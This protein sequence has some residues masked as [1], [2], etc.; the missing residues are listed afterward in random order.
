MKKKSK[1]FDY[2]I[3][4]TLDNAKKRINLLEKLDKKSVLDEYNEWLNDGLNNHTILFLRED[5]II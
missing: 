2:C 4:F 3:K 5:P 1:D